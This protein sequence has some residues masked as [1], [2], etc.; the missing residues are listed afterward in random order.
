MEERTRVE[1]GR[2]LARCYRADAM[3][4]MWLI[5]VGIVQF[6]SAAGDMLATVNLLQRVTPEAVAA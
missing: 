5:E 1:Q 2:C 4:A 6:Y 3:M